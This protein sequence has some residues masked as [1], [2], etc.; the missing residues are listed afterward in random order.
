MPNQETDLKALDETAAE[1]AAN[2]AG[3]AASRA[4]YDKL[5]ADYE[6]LK[7]ERDQLVDRTARLQA[8]FENARKRADRERQDFKDYAMGSVVE[9]FLP[10]IDNFELALKATGST[11]Q[12]RSGRGTDREADG[13]DS[14]FVAGA[15][16]S[17]GRRGVRSAPPRGT[18]LG[19][20]GRPCPI[21]TS[22]RRFGADTSFVSGCCARPWYG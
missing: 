13:R 4:E 6:Q 19:G 1:G 21:S 3:D 22:P 7:A 8:E 10:V 17:R 15:A 16:G 20:T 2:Q 12:L 11:E 18:G 5:K 9:K 14:T